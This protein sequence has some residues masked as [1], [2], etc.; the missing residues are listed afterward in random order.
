[1]DDKFDNKEIASRAI[2]MISI[3]FLTQMLVQEPQ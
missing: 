2:I 3:R 1:M